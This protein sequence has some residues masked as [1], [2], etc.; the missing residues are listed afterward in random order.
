MGNCPD[1]L[2]TEE[3]VSDNT[4]NIFLHQILPH[5]PLLQPMDKG[6]LETLKYNNNSE[7]LKSFISGIDST[8]SQGNYNRQCCL[9]D[10]KAPVKSKSYS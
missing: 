5:T 9:H 2:Y 1:H 7:L 6:V 3:M 8:Y 4:K 10:S